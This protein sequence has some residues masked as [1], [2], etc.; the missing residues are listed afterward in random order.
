MN[1]DHILDSQRYLHPYPYV[2]IKIE[3]N[4]LSRIWRQFK[5][6]GYWHILDWIFTIAV[7]ALLVMIGILPEIML[8]IMYILTHI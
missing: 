7:I 6:G 8:Y 3:N 2:W 1:N 4:L 5:N